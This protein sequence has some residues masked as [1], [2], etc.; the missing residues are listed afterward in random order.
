MSTNNGKVS[1]ELSKAVKEYVRVQAEALQ[2]LSAPVLS[3]AEFKNIVS[4][5]MTT[6]V[7]N[8][9]A[10]NRN[11]G[12]AAAAAPVATNAN[13][14]RNNNAVPPAGAAPV[15]PVNNGSGV[16]AANNG[17]PVAAANNG[18]GTS[19]NATEQQG[20]KRKMKK[21]KSKKAKKPASK[22]SKSKKH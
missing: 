13:R 5:V 17:A 6:P 20:G 1:E 21:M 7:A 10:M 14:N 9:G 8:N 3:E 16:A 4:G 18:S 22:K 11:N 2:K 15:V 19:T 12:A